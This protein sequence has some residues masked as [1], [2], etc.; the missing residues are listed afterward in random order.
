[1][2]AKIRMFPNDRD[3]CLANVFHKSTFRSEGSR[4]H[5]YTLQNLLYRITQFQQAV[6]LSNSRAAILAITSTLTPKS[7]QILECWKM[8]I[9]PQYLKEKVV[10]QLI[11]THC[12]MIGND[13]AKKGFNII[14][15]PATQL[16]H[17]TTKF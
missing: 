2:V 5:M 17:N 10:L 12:G 7:Q 8:S 4:G 14:K 13:S 6:I 15:K 11:P 9:S 1:M 16:P 3:N